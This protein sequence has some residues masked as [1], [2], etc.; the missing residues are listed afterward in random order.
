MKA[1]DGCPKCGGKTGYSG[2][3]TETHI[4]HG[5]WGEI[6]EAGSSGLDVKWGLMECNDCGAKFRVNTCQ[7]RGE[8]GAK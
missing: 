3:M 5:S 1:S 2:N 7:E 8:G 4:M 6:P